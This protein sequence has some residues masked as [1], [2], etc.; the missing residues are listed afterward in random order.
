MDG[1]MVVVGG[2]W[3]TNHARRAGESAGA[4][5]SLELDSARLWHHSLLRENS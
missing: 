1:W 2:G 3:L 5:R 4:W